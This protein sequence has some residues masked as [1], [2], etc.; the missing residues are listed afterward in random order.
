MVWR[1]SFSSGDVTALILG[2]PAIDRLERAEALRAIL[3]PPRDDERGDL[4]DMEPDHLADALK[5]G[6]A[7]T[8]RHFGLQMVDGEWQSN[9]A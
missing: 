2:D 9:T 4:G 3:P 7:A 5:S 8:A 1:A 6:A